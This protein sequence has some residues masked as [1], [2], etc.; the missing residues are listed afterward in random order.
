MLLRSRSPILAALLG[1]SALTAFTAAQT[2][3]SF[4][5]IADSADGFD[6]FDAK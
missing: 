1:G 6:P 5:V 3:Y 2:S 4:T